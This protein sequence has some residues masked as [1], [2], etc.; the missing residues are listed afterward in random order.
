MLSRHLRRVRAWSAAGLFACAAVAGAF[1]DEPANPLPAPD[2]TARA[3]DI[4]KAE[5]DGLI[6]LKVRGQGA[7]RVRFSLQS[8]SKQRLRIVLPPGLVAACTTAQ[9]GAGGFQSM[10]LGVPTD[11]PGRFGEFRGSGQTEGFRSMPVDAEPTGGIL[12]PP[13]QTVQLN[14]PSVCLNFGIDTPTPKDVFKLMTVEDYT[15]DARHRK[16]LRSAAILGTSQGVAQAIMWHVFNGMP[17]EQIA[18]QA[19]KY[20]NINEVG[21]AARF[22]QALDASDATD[23]VDPAYFT[24]A[25]VMVRVQGEGL[26]AK[27]A[28]RLNEELAGQTVLG[29][30]VRVVDEMPSSEAVLSSLFIN[31]ALNSSGSNQ[32]RGRMQVRHASIQSGWRLLGQPA[33]QADSAAA[34]LDGKALAGAID[35]AIAAAFVSARP[36]RHAPG[37]TTF[38][39]DN[40][41]PFT[42]AGIELATGAKGHEANVGLDRLGIGPNRSA[43]AA[44]PADKGIV[45]RVIAN[46]L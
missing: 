19:A 38:R 17:F 2:S 20:V 46:G 29:L 24:Q 5:Q 40:R 14:V 42:L 27:Q 28:K 10:G 37:M 43:F 22:V 6:Q 16:A 44:V 8:S 34:Q 39:I 21:L 45:Q 18:T 15:P 12:V 31:V 32:T 26:L 33:L 25:R 9:G 4:L 11:S 3:V 36:A 35:R 30:P 13:G 7:D 23:L 41:L 1:A